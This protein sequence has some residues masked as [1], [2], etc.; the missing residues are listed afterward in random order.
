MFR[1]AAVLAVLVFAQAA[2]ATHVDV[3]ASHTAGESC[4]L[5]AGFSV[6]GAG[7]AG[8]VSIP[9]HF[10]AAEAPV[11]QQRVFRPVSRSR[12]FL[13]RGPPAAS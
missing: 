8:A 3:D 13:A 10:A 11:P 1:V 2:V 9:V 5:C 4:A 12:F 6:L 7:I